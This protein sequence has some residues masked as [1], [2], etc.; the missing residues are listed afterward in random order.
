MKQQYWPIVVGSAITI[1]AATNPAYAALIQPNTSAEITS[2]ALRIPPPPVPE[3]EPGSRDSS[4]YA[5]IPNELDGLNII[6]RTEPLLIWEG[7]LSKVEIRVVDTDEPLWMQSV[8]YTERSLIY[9]GAPLEPGQHYEWILYDSLSQITDVVRFQMVAMEDRD[10]ISAEL[11]EIEAAAK[12]NRAST[13]EV[14]LERMT[15]LAKQALLADM[16]M[17]DCLADHQNGLFC[18]K[19]FLKVVEHINHWTE[20]VEFDSKGN[21][22]IHPADLRIE[23]FSGEGRKENATRLEEPYV[24]SYQSNQAED[25]WEEPMFRVKLINRSRETLFITLLD[26]TENFSVESLLEEGTIELAPSQEFWLNDGGP[27]YGV[28]PEE[29]WDKGETYCKDI[30]KVMACTA[31]FNPNLLTQGNLGEPQTRKLLQSRGVKTFGQLIGQFNGQKEAGEK[32]EKHFPQWIST[33]VTL[34]FIR[35]QKISLAI[36]R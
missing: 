30:Y 35:A 17:E 9:G 31:N 24:L 16:V 25:E 18:A 23:I 4:V 5:I 3:I 10:R 12:V 22:T 29:L 8:S 11:A 27:I 33:Q 2:I 7:A 32:F 6:W 28:I 15:Y 19:A 36:G 21:E 1:L 26:L 14:M 13:E 20:I 34:T